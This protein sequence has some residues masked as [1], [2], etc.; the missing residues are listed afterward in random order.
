MVQLARDQ[1]DDAWIRGESRARILWLVVWD[2]FLNGLGER[3]SRT[4]ARLAGLG[5]KMLEGYTMGTREGKMEGRMAWMMA[6]TQDVR[7]TLRQIRRRPTFAV[8]TVLVL[9]LGIGANTAV[10]SVV[11]GVLLRA[12]PLP[13]ADRLVRVSPVVPNFGIGGANLPGFQDWARE[14][15]P[16]EALGGFHPTVHSLTTDGT[17]ER[18]IVGSTIGDIFGVAGV[19]DVGEMPVVMAQNINAK[20]ACVVFQRRHDFRCFSVHHA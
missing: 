7:Y 5:T 3:T 16:F 20:I 13:H 4:Y 19:F 11:D 8:A 10:F 9:A 1:M 2:A 15:G 18:I 14:M 6:L 12:V 17:P